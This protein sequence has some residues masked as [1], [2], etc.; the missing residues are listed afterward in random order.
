V[1]VPVRPSGETA[2][3]RG[4]PGQRFLSTV[5]ALSWVMT[6]GANGIPG[7]MTYHASI[8]AAARLSVPEPSTFPAERVRQRVRRARK[9]LG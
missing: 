2:Q 1:S 6:S 8:F 4:S 5:L 3:E 7:I 9:S